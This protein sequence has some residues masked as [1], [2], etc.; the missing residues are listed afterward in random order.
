S[1]LQALLNITW[2]RLS[3]S[4][5]FDLPVSLLEKLKGRARRQR[6]NT[7]QGD[8]IAST[9]ALGLLG[10]SSELL[11]LAALVY[12]ANSI[13]SFRYLQSPGYVQQHIE[14]FSFVSYLLATSIVSPFFSATGFALYLNRR[15]RLEGWDIELQFKQMS[16]RI[17]AQQWK[18]PAVVLAIFL[19]LPAV[20]HT[21]HAED[22]SPKE[23]RQLILEATT[24]KEF[25]KEE[26]QKKWVP[27][28]VT[29]EQENHKFDR[30]LE[31]LRDWLKKLFKSDPNTPSFTTFAQWIRIFIWL[32]AG[33]LIIYLIWRY[34]DYLP[35]WRQKANQ[36]KPR[37]SHSPETLFG[38]DIR[39]ATLPTDIPTAAAEAW[40]QKK[41]REA[42]SLL[43]RGALSRCVSQFD[44]A[45]QAHHT[46]GDC[47]A[48]V[49]QTK[50]ELADYF[51]E[52]TRYWK[53]IA[54]GHQIPAVDF[55]QV[56]N[57]WRR[58]FAGETNVKPG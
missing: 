42:F 32:I 50:P 44:I 18:L 13:F 34:H 52:L 20:P 19:T 21:A 48:L 28:T 51:D 58:H 12:G 35:Q 23:A 54:Y 55:D 16:Q 53:N 11:I 24:G 47:S 17:A 31:A 37:Q 49:S 41:Y 4:R 29:K 22:I 14:I 46:E 15:T 8:N 39:Q 27:K 40:Q 3:P 38:L 30:L 33:L 26:K 6:L 1:W 9:F 10:F 57:A 25:Y 7:L 2:R 36:A 45:F 43:Y 5:N 56:C